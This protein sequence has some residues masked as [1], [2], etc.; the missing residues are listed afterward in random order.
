VTQYASRFHS[1]RNGQFAM[2]HVFAGSERVA[3]VMFNMPPATGPCP[4]GFIGGSGRV[5]TVTGGGGTIGPP[6]TLGSPRTTLWYHTDHLQSTNYVTD[7]RGRVTEH[8]EYFPFGEQWVEEQSGASSDT[9]PYRFTGHD[10]DS[11]TRLY[12]AGARY[13]DPRQG[14]WLSGDPALADRFRGPSRGDGGQRDERELPF[15]TTAGGAGND[16]RANAAE[17]L[18]PRHLRSYSYVYNS[19]TVAID[20]NGRDALVV[21]FPDFEAHESGQRLPWTGHAG[22]IVIENSALRRG[23]AVYYEFGRYAAG[24]VVRRYDL[25]NVQFDRRSGLPTE[26][27]LN[28]LLHRL[29][30]RSGQGGRIAGAY[31]VGGSFRA[32]QAFAT[33]GG[34]APG[35]R[36]PADAAFR[37]P[38]GAYGNWANNCLTFAC[39]V[40]DVGRSAG[41]RV[42]GE[43]GPVHHPAADVGP[44]QGAADARLDY[45]PP[46]R[47]SGHGSSR[48]R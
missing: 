31:F 10:W 35:S 41:S 30:Q 44:V 11:E 45:T 24:G 33:R 3:T 15:G 18:G 36:G 38:A 37:P 20:P 32:M 12:Y 29:S 26:R 46:G 9:V 2:D 7:A 8:L 25:G 48:W 14:Q 21:I 17:R 39:S 28:P 19:P 1:I 4:A 27:S 23:H 5:C 6:P 42:V 40:A 47:A 13:Y 34:P 43:L 22:V 16:S